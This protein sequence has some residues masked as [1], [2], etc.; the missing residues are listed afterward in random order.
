M[1]QTLPE[2]SDG[3]ILNLSQLGL[4]T[5]VSGNPISVRL[6]HVVCS[7]LFLPDLAHFKSIKSIGLSF[8]DATPITSRDHLNLKKANSTGIAKHLEVLTVSESPC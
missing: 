6:S 1:A 8:L 4:R 5:I 3:S 2:Y 7:G